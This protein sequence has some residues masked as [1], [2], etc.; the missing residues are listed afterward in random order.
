M[1][2]GCKRIKPE[3]GI[4]VLKGDVVF[5]KEDGRERERERE[6]EGERGRAR[7]TDEQAD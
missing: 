5:K 2:V 4:F 7:Q 3:L 1:V 6:R